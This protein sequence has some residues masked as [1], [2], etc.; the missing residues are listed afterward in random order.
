VF[1]LGATGVGATQVATLNDAQ[2]EDNQAF[3]RAV[4]VIP[5]RGK[6]VI[7]VSADNEIFVYFR[8]TLEDGTDLYAE[9]RQGK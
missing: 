3:G 8:A 4:T 5:Y 2:P 6:N 9:T 7:A 1:S